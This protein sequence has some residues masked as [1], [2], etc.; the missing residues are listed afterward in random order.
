MPKSKPA[1]RTEFEYTVFEIA[2]DGLALTVNK[3]NN[4]CDCLTVA[5]LKA[6]W[7]PESAVMKWSD[8]NPDWPE[9]P[10]QLYGPGTDSGTFDYFTEA[11]CGKQDASRNDFT[12]S[13]DDNVLVTGVEGDK[14][15]LGY[16]GYAYYKE[17]SDRLKLLAV[18]SGDGKCVLPTA[19]TVRDNSYK[20]LSRPLFLYVRNTSLAR[21]EVAQFVEFYLKRVG[22][23]VPQ[24]GYMTVPDEVSAKNDAD[25]CRRDGRRAEEVGSEAT[26]ATMEAS[27]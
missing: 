23:L 25:V 8:V 13:E 12:Q 24:V 20:P 15:S 18:D 17:N 22:E 1:K 4:W 2:F 19:E 27:A 7:Q 11:I 14:Y 10:M 16:F 5:Q 9:Q 21:P 3:E 6:I 26:V